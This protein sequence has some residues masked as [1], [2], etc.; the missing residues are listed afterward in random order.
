MSSTTLPTDWGLLRLPSLYRL[1]FVLELTSAVRLPALQAP[2]AYALLAR[3]LHAGGYPQEEVP[4]GCQVEAPERGRVEI[5]VGEPVAFGVTLLERNDALQLAACLVRGLTE[6]GRLRR[7][8]HEVLG[9]NFRLVEATDLV[10]GADLLINKQPRPLPQEVLIAE[11]NQAAPQ[12]SLTL[13]FQGPLLA[14]RRSKDAQREHGSTFLDQRGFEAGT[15][16]EKLQDRFQSLGLIAGAQEDLTRHA[17]I[18][19]LDLHWIEERRYGPAEGRKNRGGVLGTVELTELRPA[20]AR[21]LAIGQR[22][23]LGQGLAWGGGRYRLEELGPDPFACHPAMDLLEH[24]TVGGAADSHARDLAIEEDLDP[25]ELDAWRQH[26]AQGRHEIRPPRRILMQQPNKRP[27]LLALPSQPDRLLQRLIHRGLAPAMDGLLEAASHAYRRGKGI[28]SAADELLDARRAGFAWQLKADFVRFFDSIDHRA[29]RSRLEALLGP[30]RLVELLMA[31]VASGAPQRGLGLSTG[32]P[33]SPLLSNLFLDSFDEEIERRGWRLVR[34]ADDFLVLFKSEADAQAV[35]QQVVEQAA[36]LSQRI[37]ESKSQLI[38]PEE[39]FDFLGM[40]FSPRDP[41]PLHEGPQP[42][43]RLGWRSLTSTERSGGPRPLLLPGESDEVLAGA[44][45]AVLVGP[46]AIRLRLSQGALR[47]EMA[48]GQ[49]IDL[50]G[51]TASIELL[52]SPNLTLAA[53]EH[54]GE[55]NIDLAIVDPQGYQT[56]L[57]SHPDRPLDADLVVAQVQAA[58]DPEA[59]LALAKQWIQAKL[60]NHCA[61]LRAVDQ[62]GWHHKAEALLDTTSRRAAEARTVAE[63]LGLEGHGARTWYR[64]LRRLLPREWAFQKRVAPG[65]TDPINALMNLGH[66]VIHRRLRTTLQS[67]GLCDSIGLLHEPRSGHA[68]LASDLQEPF[69]HLVDR[70]I[71]SCIHLLAHEDFNRI[72]DGRLFLTG[73][74]RLRLLAELQRQWHRSL[75][76]SPDSEP[77]SYQRLAERQVRELTAWLRDHRRLPSAIQYQM[78]RSSLPPRPLRR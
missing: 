11:A 21:L 26:L 8:I 6:V 7:R 2:L 25:L 67:A 53:L 16:L 31:W 36:E 18:E 17:R 70:W 19:S 49:S 32:A 37:H 40:R 35:W 34:Y 66:A 57:S 72:P 38:G 78:P 52:G 48:T 54:A 1:R 28:K 64:S 59:R 69:R 75:R 62:H 47:V 20:A 65:A 73:S 29:L 45:A 42:L 50:P 33:L 39:S 43:G 10:S 63:L 14:R 30:G 13:R 24:L 55:R 61:L 71:L 4:S 3:A 60:A 12:R 9:G 23:G 76:L 51:E 44:G 15:L 46:D 41:G 68:S 56:R 58:A 77:T 5:R 74:A 22:L 27:R